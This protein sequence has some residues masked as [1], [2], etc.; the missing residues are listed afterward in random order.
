MSKISTLRQSS[1]G[2]KLAASNFL[3]VSIVFAVFIFAISYAVSKTIEARAITD[4]AE[5]TTLL[6]NL[7]ESS[8]KDLRMRSSA[9][10]Q[11]FR[12]SLGNQIEID[13]A[14]VD[15][16]GKP[17][18]T[19]KI[20]GQTANL[21]FALVDHFTE[22]TGAV[23]TI[24]ARNGDDFVRITTSLKNANGERAI[25]T[26]LDHAHP[27]YKATLEGATYTG[28][29]TLFGKQYVTQYDPIKD[30]QGKVIGLSFI[31]INFNEYLTNLKTYMRNLKLGKTG[32]FY[33]LD[34]KP[35]SGYGKFIVHPTL[36]GKNM[37]DAKDASGNEF[38]KEIL[39]RKDGSTRYPWINPELGETSPR[40]KVAAFTYM[41][42]WNW[43][44]V[45]GAYADEYSAEVRDLRNLFM[46]LGIA[47]VFVVSGLLYVLVRRMVIAPL[48]VA[49]AAGQAIARGDLTIELTVTSSDEVGQL[50]ASMNT[51]GSGL[52]GV[53]QSVRLGSESVASAS[54]EIAQGNND[55]SARTEQQASA[56]EETASSMEELSA[57]VRQ[58]ADSAQQA[59]QL[60]LSAST[61]A[62]QGGEVVAQVVATMKDINH[63]SKKIA[64][65]ISVIDGIAFQ[66]N[67]LALNA[68]VE[69]ARAG[70]Q[71]RGF[72]VVAT[73]VRSLAGRSAQAAKEIKSLIN[74][75]VEKVAQ[76]T[77]QVDQAGLTMG[78]VVAGIRRV[79][80]LMVEIS[81]ASREQS[82][83]VAQVGEAVTQMDQVTQ[84]NAALVEEMAA[85]AGSLKSQAEDLVQTVE[86]FKLPQDQRGASKP[87][88]DSANYARHSAS[89]KPALPSHAFAPKRVTPPAKPER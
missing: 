4:L 72:A 60:A 46:V 8:D 86:V 65:I 15:I 77:A 42:S 21:N 1:I 66:T 50:M 36:E 23:A 51:I 48:G 88:Q 2:T 84:Q 19:L 54:F 58:N 27:G 17:T 81:A 24:F 16:G 59:S 22:L 67:I 70:E 12:N 11:A 57:T 10:A 31:G 53:V 73:E 61:V 56:L 29:A 62:A 34:A 25:G 52:A 83:G 32:Y 9:L 6:K 76:G 64:D 33:V 87:T 40:D 14:T 85:A 79:T 18:P 5:R 41:T 26:L 20:G 49:T 75:S 44:I 30:A 63:S 47:L 39:E 68:A 45:G 80:D 89:S 71:G 55:L 78:E 3:L 37:V 43:I 7:I 74:T 69:A 13:A 38:I 35:G 28:L 82:Q